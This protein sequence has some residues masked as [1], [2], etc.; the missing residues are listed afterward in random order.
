ML[1]LREK[2]RNSKFV[3][4]VF[5]RIRT[6][7]EDLQNKYPYS[8]RMLENTDQ[9]NTKFEHFLRSLRDLVSFVRLLQKFT[10]RSLSTK[11]TAAQ[12]QTS[13]FQDVSKHS[14]CNEL[15]SFMVSSNF[16]TNF[17][18]IFIWEFQSAAFCFSSL[19]LLKTCSYGSV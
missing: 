10:I 6:E 17:L 3:W 13:F 18:L 7:Y 8:L 2:C 15:C 12:R 14:V 19:L 4:S 1:T 16:A 11:T 5:S 9:K